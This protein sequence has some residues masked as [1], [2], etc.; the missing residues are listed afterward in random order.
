MGAYANVLGRVVFDGPT[1]LHPILSEAMNLSKMCRDMASETYFILLILTDGE[2]H[3]LQASINDIIA[4]SHLPLSI[5]IV[6]VGNA[7]FKN[8]EVLDND[9]MTMVDSSG[10]AILLV[11]LFYKGRKA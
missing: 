8:M 1:Y 3:D 11:N 4:S 5:I 2:T 9:D 10:K 7:D 6:G